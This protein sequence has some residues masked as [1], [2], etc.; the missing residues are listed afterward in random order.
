[1]KVLAQHRRQHLLGG[2]FA[3]RAGDLHHGDVKLAPIPGRKFPQ[4]R[5]G[6]IHGD[7]EFPGSSP[8]G[9]WA[10]RQPAAPF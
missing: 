4:R 5:L 10:H 8:S 9:I 7:V 3:R 2:G 6:V 1:M